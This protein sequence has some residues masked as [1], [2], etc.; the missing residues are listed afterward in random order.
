MSNNAVG[1]VYIECAPSKTKSRPVSP[2]IRR[3]ILQ[4]EVSKYTTRL[5]VSSVGERAEELWTVRILDRMD[6]KRLGLVII[7][8]YNSPVMAIGK[9]DPASSASISKS[10]EVWYP[11]GVLPLQE[12]V[13]R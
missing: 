13:G 2:I 6:Q 3:K 9:A 8:N 10:W 7:L 4:K 1:G 5:D 11:Q 12:L